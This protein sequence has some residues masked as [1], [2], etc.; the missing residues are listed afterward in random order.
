MLGALTHYMTTADPQHYQPM[1]SNWA[2]LPP[3]DPPPGK[4]KWGREEKA[5][6]LVARAQQ[7]M[8]EFLREMRL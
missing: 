8:D 5:E 3:L 2:L 6:K 7:A 4:K 1:N